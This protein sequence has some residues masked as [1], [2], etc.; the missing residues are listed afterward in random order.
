MI[1]AQQAA[2][3]EAQRKEDVQK[4][5]LQRLEDQLQLQR[6]A[7]TA[8]GKR[9]D[10]E[11]LKKLEQERIRAVALKRARDEEMAKDVSREEKLSYIKRSNQALHYISMTIIPS[12]IRHNQNAE[13]PK[14]AWDTISTIFEAFTKARKL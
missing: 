13:N 3:G 2:I 12:L 14:K 5:E 7:E 9:E 10:D 11:M 4:E 6:A 8:A 1:E